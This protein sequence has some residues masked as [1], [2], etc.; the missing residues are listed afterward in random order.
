MSRKK[1]SPSAEQKVHVKKE[2]NMFA[3]ATV[4]IRLKS[5]KQLVIFKKQITS[6]HLTLP[7]TTRKC[8]KTTQQQLK[9]T[10]NNPTTIENL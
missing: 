5:L 2:A 10:Q 6:P 4:K 8:P 9:T 3:A 1:W 7:K